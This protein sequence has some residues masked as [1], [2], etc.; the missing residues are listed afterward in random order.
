MNASITTRN[1]AYTLF[2]PAEADRI[3]AAMGAE[4]PDWQYVAMHDPKG[5]GRSFVEIRDDDGHVVGRV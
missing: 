1:A 2:A 4:D 3:A 5:T